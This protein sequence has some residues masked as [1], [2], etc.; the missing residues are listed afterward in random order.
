MG[1]HMTEYKRNHFGFGL[2]V[3]GMAGLVASA[4]L[5]DLALATWSAMVIVL[6]VVAGPLKEK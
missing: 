3:G 5:E 2:L 6:A 4:F 1:A